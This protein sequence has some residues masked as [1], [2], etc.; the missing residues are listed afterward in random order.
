MPKIAMTYAP[1]TDSYQSAVGLTLA[2]ETDSCPRPTMVAPPV[3]T[4]TTTMV[5]S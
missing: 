5:G 2:R 1:A 3:A 4:R